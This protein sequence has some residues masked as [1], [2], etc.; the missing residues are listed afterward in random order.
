VHAEK[1]PEPAMGSGSFACGQEK[2][3]EKSAS[4]RDLS[5]FLAIKYIAT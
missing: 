3:E 1:E 4:A 2:Y 5:H